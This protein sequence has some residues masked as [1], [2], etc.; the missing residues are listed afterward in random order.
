LKKLTQNPDYYKQISK[1]IPDFFNWQQKES[2][3]RGFSI[4]PRVIQGDEDF[5]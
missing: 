2:K 3:A 4:I 5:P 1:R